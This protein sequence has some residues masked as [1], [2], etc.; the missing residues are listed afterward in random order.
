MVMR[1]ISILAALGLVLSAVSTAGATAPWQEA[2]TGLEFVNVA[3]G[4]YQ[5]G[6]DATEKEEL[7]MLLGDESAGL[8]FGDELPVREVCVADYNLG[9][10]EVTVAAFRKFVEATGY[11]TE[12]E[13]GGG[14][15]EYLIP[16]YYWQENPSRNWREPGFTQKDNEP[17]VCV[18]WNDARAFA[19]WLS[20]GN[21]GKSFRLATEAEWEYAARDRGK[22]KKFNAALK[23]EETGWYD[24][25]SPRRTSPVGRKKP[26]EVGAFDLYGNVWEWVG[27]YYDLRGYASGS[28][29]NPAGPAQGAFRVLRGG[30]WN[31]FAW[32]CR[33]AKRDR[34]LASH[35]DTNLGFRLVYTGK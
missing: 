29:D 33:A 11:R 34:A 22:L 16:R 32:N 19:D 3:G 10:Q 30:G 8:T 25:N 27:D 1:K 21:P 24:K 31:S 9:R 14:C 28:K 18:S 23:L 13:T 15:Q 12:A 4:C 20:K 35:R 6:Q 17:V 5:M 7:S 26:G 2:K